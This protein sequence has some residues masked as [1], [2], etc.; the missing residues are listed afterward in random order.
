MRQ[1][2]TTLYVCQS[3]PVDWRPFLL[4]WMPLCKLSSGQSAAC[5]LSKYF[6]ANLLRSTV[7]TATRWCPW[8][9]HHTGSA[10]PE[11][12]AAQAGQ[13]FAILFVDASNAFYSPLRRHIV[14]SNADERGVKMSQVPFP[15]VRVTRSSMG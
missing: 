12:P 6:S 15:S 7:A 13:S 5:D 9:Q 14:G 1:Y 3:S 8:I 10:H 4:G 11:A 2:I